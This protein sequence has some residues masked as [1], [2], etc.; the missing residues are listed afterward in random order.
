MSVVENID[1]S[2]IL[3]EVAIFVNRLIIGFVV[4]Y[5]AMLKCVSL[6][7][8]YDIPHSGIVCDITPLQNISFDMTLVLSKAYVSRST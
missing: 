7:N 5:Y 3:M 6:W 4:W 8:Q 2:I 1:L